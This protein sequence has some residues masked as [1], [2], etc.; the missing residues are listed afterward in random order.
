VSKTAS[1]YFPR[2]GPGQAQDH[3]ALA[4]LERA[5][6]ADPAREGERLPFFALRDLGR[7]P[8]GLS[9]Q[10]LPASI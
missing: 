7:Y 4:V 8:P 1:A 2:L 5:G 6:V 9:Y 10:A 3:A